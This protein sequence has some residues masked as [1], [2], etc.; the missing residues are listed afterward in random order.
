MA[1]EMATVRDAIYKGEWR[2][3]LKEARG[4]VQLQY[5]I[6]HMLESPVVIKVDGNGWGN[7]GGDHNTLFDF[8]GGWGNGSGQ[9]NWTGNGWGNAGGWGLDEGH[10]AD[11]HGDVHNVLSRWDEELAQDFANFHGEH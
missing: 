4:P 7:A 9:D 1:T 6:G 10:P 11:A 3:A 2:K 8:S 5:V